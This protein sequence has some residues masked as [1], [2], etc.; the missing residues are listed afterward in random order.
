M[1]W[2]EL[3]NIC[4]KYGNLTNKDKL[5]INIFVI[6]ENIGKFRIYYQIW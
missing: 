6:D 1:F 2:Q 4:A 3:G 5:N